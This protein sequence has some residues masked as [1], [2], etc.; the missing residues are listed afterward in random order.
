[1]VVR[2]LWALAVYD[3]PDPD[4]FKKGIAVLQARGPETLSSAQTAKLLWS[5]AQSP[6][7]AFQE[8]YLSTMKHA[9]DR[10]ETTIEKRLMSTGD[11]ALAGDALL[12]LCEA[13]HSEISV[14]KNNTESIRGARHRISQLEETVEDLMDA[15]E[16]LVDCSVDRV[17]DMSVACII[18]VLR[19][20]VTIG[21][22]YPPQLWE[23]C[24]KRLNHL[25]ANP[26]ASAHFSPWESASMLELIPFAPRN[27]TVEFHLEKAIWPFPSHL[28][29]VKNDEVKD[30]FPGSRNR[31]PSWHRLAGRLAAWTCA[32]AT[33]L[34]DRHHLIN[35]CWGLACLGHPH[36]TLLR[37]V[38]KN[39]Q[40]ALHELSP[41]VLSRLVVAV[42]LEE[43]SGAVGDFARSGVS[44]V[45]KLDREFVDQVALSVFKTVGDV[46]P[47]SSQ[48]SA[49]VAA[50]GL[51]RLT[52]FD[53]RSRSKDG[54]AAV[55]ITVEKL[56]DIPTNSLIKLLWAAGRLPAGVLS[57]E[58][59]S[60]VRQELRG[61]ELI[62]KDRVAA[63]EIVSEQDLKLYL[64]HLIDRRSHSPQTG[65]SPKDGAEA[66]CK[67]ML[68]K[69]REQGK[70]LDVATAVAHLSATEAASLCEVLWSYIDLRWFN[71]EAL[72]VM[73]TLCTVQ[74][75]DYYK[76]KAQREEKANV[77][78]FLEISC[79]WA[80]QLGRL[81][82][83]VGIYRAL[84]QSSS[85]GL[86]LSIT[87]GPA[88][89]KK[90]PRVR[91]LQPRLIGMGLSNSRN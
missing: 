22:A 19:C 68:A 30:L 67:A 72:K 87:S 23:R 32:Q 38:R 55:S 17:D 34:K 41:D 74:Q 3:V 44:T 61:R 13:A 59:I 71:A 50:A 10:L 52:A 76:N 6:S 8:A 64:R 45:A 60:S 31:N 63:E 16:T 57:E 66:V 37:Y 5:L 58:T 2:F 80:Y 65:K 81:E 77:P 12:S 26:S 48:I 56:R 15:M 4:L 49:L 24:L 42:A 90:Y 88:T 9:L 25:T 18:S 91:R 33:V 27:A 83:L 78:Y 79:I 53:L 86:S 1:M 46:T 70:D 73:E 82:E 7:L 28:S 89:T 62:Q 14:L 43:A 75:R 39:V 51:G 69:V 20:A 29:E 47:L 85:S 54:H 35:S 11:V 84:T 36:R 21:E 40:F